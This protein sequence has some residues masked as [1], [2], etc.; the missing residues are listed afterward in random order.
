MASR[1]RLWVTLER[2]VAID[3]F[4]VVD[5]GDEIALTDDGVRNP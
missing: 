1:P 4:E 3:D 5:L 2:G